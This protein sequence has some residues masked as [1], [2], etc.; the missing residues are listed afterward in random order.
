MA[1]EIS[2]DLNSLYCVV[3]RG[4]REVGKSDLARFVSQS[5]GLSQL[6]ID[7]SVS[8]ARSTLLAT[9][10]PLHNSV[11]RIV[12]VEEYD[13]IAETL[14]IIRDCIRKAVSDQ[15]PVG[16]FV[17][18]ASR[19]QLGPCLASDRLGTHVGT[20]DLSPITLPEYLESKN[21]T[22]G[23][24]RV[25]GL[26][27]SITTAPTSAGDERNSIQALWLRGGFPRSLSPAD[28]ADSLH[29]RSQY[30]SRIYDGNYSHIHPL[31]L[32]V[33]IRNIMHRIAELQGAVMYKGFKP[34]ERALIDHFAKVGILRLLYPWTGSYLKSSNRLP[35]VYVRD[36]GLLHA[37][38]GSPTRD[39]L[40]S[41]SKALGF[42][43]EGF[44]IEQILT[45]VPHIE[46]YFYRANNDDEVDLILQISTQ[47]FVAIEFGVSKTT[48][49]RGFHLAMSSIGTTS[50]YLVADVP[51]S[52][53]KVGYRVMTLSDMIRQLSS[54]QNDR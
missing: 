37:I 1:S 31:L 22:V 43:W 52:F 21:E 41:N 34:E 26:E 44:C 24:A 8:S 5:S 20:F 18:V 16:R 27:E 48:A 11:G 9:N 13:A 12:V 49:S 46:A 47:R 15:T 35:R 51:E 6:V 53:E 33:S 4:P 19:Q 32:A 30:L 54:S 36:S 25:I 42:S 7:A 29:W 23:D 39:N 10:G 45:N 50:G 38:L 40:S 2:R 3:I 14:D 28:D 17:L